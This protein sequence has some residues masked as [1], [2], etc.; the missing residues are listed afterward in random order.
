MELLSESWKLNGK[1]FFELF[2]LSDLD[3]K[4]TSAGYKCQK[5][6]L[7]NSSCNLFKNVAFW[8]FTCK[9]KVQLTL[10]NFSLDSEQLAPNYFLYS[11]ECPDFHLEEILSQ[12]CHN[13]DWIIISPWLPATFFAC[14][15]NQLTWQNSP[16]E[17]IWWKKLKKWPVINRATMGRARFIIYPWF[18]F[19]FLTA[20]PWAERG[21]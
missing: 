8:I 13:F 18:I 9:T 6:T 12:F 21:S 16:K 19:I 15:F 4:I 1:V 20:W 5:M 7:C 3:K 14:I 2:L 17:G 10:N 11:C